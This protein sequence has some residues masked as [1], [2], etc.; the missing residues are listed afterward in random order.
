MRRLGQTYRFAGFRLDTNRRILSLQADGQTIPLPTPAFDTL[1]YL[2]EHAG[3]LVERKA[4][5][6]AVWPHVTVVENSVSQTISALR[7]ALGDDADA[8]RFVS[9]VAGRGYRFLAQVVPEDTATRSAEAYQFYAAGW[10]AL[11]RPSGGKL[12]AALEFLKQA[13]SCDPGFALAHAHLAD[14]YA[15]ACV[16]G[17]I[18]AR[19]AIPLLRQAAERAMK[20]DPTLPEAHVACARV[21]ELAEQNFPAA[22]ATLDHAVE[23]DPLCFTAYRYRGIYLINFGKFDEALAALR[24]A[25]TIQPLAVYISTNI[26]MV[27]YYAGRYQEALAQFELILRMEPDQ[28]LARA[29]LGR[30]LLQLGEASRAIRELGQGT[31]TL[32]AHASNLPVAWAAAGETDRVRAALA[33]ILKKPKMQSIDAARIYAALGDQEEAVTWLERA[34]AAHM[35]GLFSVDPNFWSLHGHPRFRALVDRLGFRM[36]GPGGQLDA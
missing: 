26:G 7:R 30:T 24:K 36:V 31:R 28:E 16:H 6:A 9:T 17:L 20:A 21:Q 2:I 25:Q 19:E 14:G 33:E 32:R 12:A 35:P 8:P 1:L 22:L 11:T 3:E 18:P 23:L 27:L 10:S 15:M 13:V 34:V 29:F 5:L 4:L